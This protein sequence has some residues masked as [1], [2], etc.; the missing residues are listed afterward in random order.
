[1]SY[2]YALKN[3]NEASKIVRGKEPT[4]REIDTVNLIQGL[5]LIYPEGFTVKRYQSSGY[6]ETV[7]IQ[8]NGEPF[9]EILEKLA[10]A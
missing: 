4:Q 8:F 3:L 7:E 2:A 1:M 6:G 9:P 5:I 10:Y